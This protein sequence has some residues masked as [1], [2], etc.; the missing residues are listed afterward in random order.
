[1]PNQVNAFGKHLGYETKLRGELSSMDTLYPE[2]KRSLK[3]SGG[4]WNQGSIDLAVRYYRNSFDDDK[5]YADI[6]RL[7]D[8]GRVRGGIDNHVQAPFERMGG[9]SPIANDCW[10]LGCFHSAKTF[11]LNTLDATC[12]FDIE[13]ALK[14]QKSDD[15]WRRRDGLPR[16]QLHAMTVTRREISSLLLF[17]YEVQDTSGGKLLFTCKN[18]SIP[19]EATLEQYAKAT[20]LHARSRPE[21]MRFIEKY[22]LGYKD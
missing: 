3:G 10:M 4:K 21:I 15:E 7:N 12:H 1:M 20:T 22:F 19:F 6:G 17:G 16:A 8:T 14:T 2:F 13:K 18:P 11:R 5:T 9:W